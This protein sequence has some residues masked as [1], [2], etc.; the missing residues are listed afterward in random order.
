[1]GAGSRTTPAADAN[2]RVTAVGAIARA[3]T[4][5]PAMPVIEDVH[6]ITREV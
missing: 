2:G 6:F 4:A 1:M 5:P 3:L